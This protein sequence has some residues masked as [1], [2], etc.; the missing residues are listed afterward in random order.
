MFL[1]EKLRNDPASEVRLQASEALS[2]LSENQSAN[3]SAAGDAGCNELEIDSIFAAVDERG[4][5]RVCVA[6]FD[7]KGEPV[8]D[9]A[10]QDFHIEEGGVEIAHSNFES[11]S[12]RD[13]LSLACVLDCSG[14]HVNRASSREMGTAVA[15][16]IEDKQPEDRISIYKY[17]FYVERAVEFTGSPKRL[18]AVIK[19]P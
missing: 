9:L 6:V 1:L 11:P 8:T 10:E 3:G 12:Q 15:K 13:P 5:R 18:T 4:R 7:G 19:R 14:K 17:A 2:K 16:Y